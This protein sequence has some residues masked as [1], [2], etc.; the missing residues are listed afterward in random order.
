M[1][2]IGAFLLLHA[3][4]K[5]PNAAA[6]PRPIAGATQE[7]KLLGVGSS[8]WFGWGCAPSTALRTPVHVTPC[9]RFPYFPRT[10]QPLQVRANTIKRAPAPPVAYRCVPP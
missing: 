10:G 7:R 2:D 5:L 3:D 1:R 4:V 6:Q 8:A 9:S